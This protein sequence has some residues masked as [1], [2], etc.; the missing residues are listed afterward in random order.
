ML[1]SVKYNFTSKIFGEGTTGFFN[2]RTY[3][4]KDAADSIFFQHIKQQLAKDW[5]MIILHFFKSV[6]FLVLFR[7]FS[8]WLPSI[9]N[10]PLFHL[11]QNIVKLKKLDGQVANGY[12]AKV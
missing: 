4:N 12:S 3:T 8:K 11:K 7:H 2:N 9:A 10:L 5:S 1:L 6:L